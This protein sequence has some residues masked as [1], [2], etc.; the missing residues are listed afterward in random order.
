MPKRTPGN[1]AAEHVE[2]RMKKI[3]EQIKTD[4][5]T[6]W[7]KLTSPQREEIERRHKQGDS[8]S[9]IA[10]KASLTRSFVHSYVLYLNGAA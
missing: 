1:P 8:I 2:D 3:K 7:Q 4:L 10:C 6:A 5:S 9:Q